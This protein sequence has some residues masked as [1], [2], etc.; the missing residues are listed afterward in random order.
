MKL[1]VTGGTG[2]IGSHFLRAALAAGHKVTAM[3]RPG[4]H[5]RVPVDGLVKWVDGELGEKWFQDF[6]DLSEVCLVHLASYGVSP[7]AC[8]WDLA[9]QINVS[10]SV[11]FL[12]AAVKAGIRRVI[13]CGTCLEYGRSAS[14]YEFVPSTAPLEPIGPYASSK[15]AQ[16]VAFAGMARELRIEMAILRPFT[17]FGEGQYEAN[18]WPSLQKAALAGQD[19]P[20]TSGEQIRDFI[21]VTQVANVFL[22]AATSADLKPGEPVIR[23]VGTGVPQSLRSFAEAQWK[24]SG[25]TGK[26]LP[27]A[28][29][30]RALEVMRYVPEIVSPVL[31]RPLGDP[32]D[33]VPSTL[34]R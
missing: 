23:N 22:E 7:Q 17:V 33:W 1:V 6:G 25:A 30:M 15:A 5:P 3:R 4:S 28:A 31:A 13:V 2:F 34:G 11:R 19:F 26:L 9:F 27:G 29:P 16:S 12:A 10:D 20:M 8:E 18:F 24:A 32:R 14:R 21:E